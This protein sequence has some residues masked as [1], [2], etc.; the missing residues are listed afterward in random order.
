MYKIDRLLLFIALLTGFSIGLI[1]GSASGFHKGT[2]L[3]KTKAIKAGAAYYD[4]N[5]ETGQPEFKWVVE[6]P[7]C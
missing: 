5:K 4:T 3:N 7:G 6:R 1:I 2:E